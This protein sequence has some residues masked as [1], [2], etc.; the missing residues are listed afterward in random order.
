MRG[1][2]RRRLDGHRLPHVLAAA[3]RLEGRSLMAADPSLPL[4]DIGTPAVVDLWVDPVR[5]SD[6][7]PGATREQA[8]RTLAEAWRRV[9]EGVPLTAGFRINLAA[10][11][12]GA[13]N[14]KWRLL[15]P[16]FSHIRSQ[17][18]RLLFS[19]IRRWLWLELKSLWLRGGAK[20]TPAEQ[21]VPEPGKTA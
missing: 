16:G 20:T 12:Y 10:G 6:A 18:G 17:S 14:A 15:I 5:G 2:C 21:P 1:P 3:E 7:A 19:G 11:T 13:R 8:L 4:L 9:P